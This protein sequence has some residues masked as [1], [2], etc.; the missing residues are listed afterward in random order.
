VSAPLWCGYVP[1]LIWSACGR[2]RWNVRGLRIL[3]QRITWRGG[4]S[5]VETTAPI[6]L[7]WSCL[8]L[9]LCYTTPEVTP[10]DSDRIMCQALA[11]VQAISALGRCR[12]AQPA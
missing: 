6:G 11:L 4:V 9:A 10:M 2:C 3:G 1:G 12:T 7:G 5:D 8:W